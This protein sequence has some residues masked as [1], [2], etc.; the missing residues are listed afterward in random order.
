MNK[1]SLSRGFSDRFGK[2]FCFDSQSEEVLELFKYS[3]AGFKIRQTCDL[4]WHDSSRTHTKLGPCS[5][6]V[7]LHPR[8]G[9]TTT[10][11]GGCI[12]NRCVLRGWTKIVN[13]EAG[14]H[15]FWVFGY[16]TRGW[17]ETSQLAHPRSAPVRPM[18]LPQRSN[19]K[20]IKC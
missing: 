10:Q 12:R 5:T 13:N 6:T 8:F 15:H 4:M 14:N 16:Y 9:A 2:Q 1:G 19:P 11:A 17:A 18:I 3:V 20:A 7:L